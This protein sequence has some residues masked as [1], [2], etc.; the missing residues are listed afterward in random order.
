MVVRSSRSPAGAMLGACL[1]A[2]TLLLGGCGSGERA[3]VAP[4][5]T[6]VGTTGLPASDPDRTDST[7]G[8]SGA[9]P[10]TP[11]VT[12][13]SDPSSDSSAVTGSVAPDA[14]ATP[15]SAAP[16]APDRPSAPDFR[17]EL[18]DGGE[19]VLSEE[20]RPVFLVFWAEW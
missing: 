1:L 17:L 5:A 19:F 16:P 3:T 11:P 15:E 6:A 14:T 18:G 7:D 2:G 9:V 10:D 4:P 13:A 12:T 20:S 8:E